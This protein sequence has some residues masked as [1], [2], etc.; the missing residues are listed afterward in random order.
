MRRN[1]FLNAFLMKP[2]SVLY[3]WGVLL[4]N[5]M[6]DWGIL[7]QRKF[8]I[9]IVV[10]G[11]LAVGG[12][13]KTPHTEYVVN[14]LKNDYHIAVLSRG[15]RRKTKGFILASRHSTPADIG[16]EPYQI[17]QK[18]GHEVRVAVCEK[19]VKGI[20]ELLRLDPSINLIVLDDAFQHRYVKPSAAVVL[21]EWNR[22]VYNDDLMPLGRL[23][24]PQRSLLR[25]DIVVVT[26]CPAEIRPMDVRLIYDHLGLFAYQKVYFSRY[27]YGNLVS[28]FPDEVNYVPNVAW[29]GAEDSVLLVS[30]IA[31]PAPLSRFLKGNGINVKLKRFPDH[32]NFTRKDFEDIMK[33]FKQLDGKTKYIITTEKDAVRIANN[34]YYPHE[35]KSLTFYLPIKVEFLQHKMPLG[36]DIFDRELRRIVSQPRDNQ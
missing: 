30:G 27:V 1:K 28:V 33:A 6:F 12:T 14:L 29:L 20:E 32:H 8:D 19:R 15:Y 10:V 21:M 3:G 5:R 7:K 24:E 4:R 31:N 34:P 18:F 11:N 23:R 16:D 2:L 25:S 36:S 9:P 22:P 13:G 26:K 35:L 17:Y